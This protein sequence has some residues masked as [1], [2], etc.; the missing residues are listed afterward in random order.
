MLYMFTYIYISV[1]D[2]DLDSLGSLDPDPDSFIIQ[3][4]NTAESNKLSCLRNLLE[5]KKV[6][7]MT[8]CNIFLVSNSNLGLEEFRR[9][10]PAQV[11]RT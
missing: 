7:N 2:S 9:D 4:R 11:F 1:T 10:N 5:P 8:Y 3:I 6:F